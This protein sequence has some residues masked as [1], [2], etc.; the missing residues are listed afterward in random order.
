MRH[1]FKRL[2]TPLLPCV[3]PLCSTPYSLCKSI[4]KALHA[5]NMDIR[6]YIIIWC[7]IHNAHSGKILSFSKILTI[8]H[9]KKNFCSISAIVIQAWYSKVKT[10]TLL[11]KNYMYFIRENSQNLSQKLCEWGTRSHQIKNV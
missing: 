4:S 9:L 10:I 1:H 6:K 11:H 3:T 7:L 2:F 5:T 8:T